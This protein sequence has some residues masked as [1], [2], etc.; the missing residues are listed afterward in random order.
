M[1][2][3]SFLNHH[4]E[5]QLAA[6]NSHFYNL[7]E[8]RAREKF[9]RILIEVADPTYEESFFDLTWKQAFDSLSSEDRQSLLN[10]EP[11]LEKSMWD[12][13]RG[14]RSKRRNLQP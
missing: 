11:S 13:L 3:A 14:E 12:C 8:A 1:T 10:E 2:I 7:F 5:L 6:C 4:E 9:L